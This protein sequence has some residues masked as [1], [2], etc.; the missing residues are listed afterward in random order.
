MKIVCSKNIVKYQPFGCSSG[1]IPYL[2]ACEEFCILDLY[3]LIST[4]MLFSLL[5]S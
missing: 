3:P 5:S 1:V 4:S 2:L